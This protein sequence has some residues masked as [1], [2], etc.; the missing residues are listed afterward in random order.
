MTAARQQQ[1]QQLAMLRTALVGVLA[2]SAA[3]TGSPFSLSAVGGEGGGRAR[4]VQR[5]VARPSAIMPSPRL[6]VQR[7]TRLEA[8]TEWKEEERGEASA[9]AEPEA[10]AK[11]AAT[12]AA[13][14]DGGGGGGGGGSSTATAAVTATATAPPLESRKDRRKFVTTLNHATALC[15]KEDFEPSLLA[16]VLE[17]FQ[18][19]QAAN[20]TLPNDYYDR[21]LNLLAKHQPEECVASFDKYVAGY[22]V[23][24]GGRGGGGGGDVAG[25]VAGVVGR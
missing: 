3:P 16:N 13:T 24:G 9:E 22:E 20:I 12:A 23:R 21:L 6:A 17:L 8:A 10:G 2:L 18:T 15:F 25:V 7:G 14:I 19:A 5:R 1:Q 4:A 11:P